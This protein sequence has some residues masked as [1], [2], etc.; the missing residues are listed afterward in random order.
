MEK[1]KCRNCRSSDCKLYDDVFCS[2]NCRKEFQDKMS[3]ISKRCQEAYAKDTS[4]VS[5][6]SKC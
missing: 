4:H 2:V 6:L 5:K 3:D 1:K